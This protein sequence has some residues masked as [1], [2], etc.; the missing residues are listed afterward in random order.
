MFSVQVADL[1][2]DGKGD[3]VL[4]MGAAQVAVLLNTGGGRSFTR[5][6]LGERRGIVY[7]GLAGYA[8]AYGVAAGDL[9]NDG[10]PDLAVARFFL[11][12]MV[13][14]NSLRTTDGAEGPPTLVW[15]PLVEPD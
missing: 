12:S 1:N 3:V 15:R 5:L 9:N 10:A 14:M 2:G 11:P 6:G 4:G 7:Y 8:I 13:Y